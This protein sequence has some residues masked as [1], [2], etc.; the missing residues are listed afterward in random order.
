MIRILALV[1]GN[2]P[3]TELVIN[4]PLRFLLEQEKIIFEVRYIK[5]VI[6]NIVYTNFKAYDVVM[7]LRVCSEYSSTTLLS[8]IK[9]A[10]CKT[11][12][13]L[14]DY[15]PLLP[16]NFDISILYNNFNCKIG[17]EN[18]CKNCDSVITFSA[19]TFNLLKQFNTK[20]YLL[21]ANVDVDY[22]DKEYN[23]IN[24]IKTSPQEIKIGYAAID[25]HYSNFKIAIP[26]IKKLLVEFPNI[27]FECFFNLKPKEFKN[28]KNFICIPYVSGINNFYKILLS[29]NWDIGIA[30]LIET[31]FNEHKTDNKFREYAACRIPG[32]YSDIAT[33]NNSVINNITGIL[34]KNDID[35]ASWYRTIKSLII[36][37]DKRKL[38][39]DTAYK[40]I[41]ENY[42][43]P[44]VA[45]KYEEIIN[46]VLI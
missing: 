40:Y 29:R 12:Y 5:E 16:Q 9:N 25:H 33:F 11:I 24:K 22:I 26:A 36:D 6:H 41:V 7:F 21:K 15:F 35:N 28:Y 13:L 10:G 30:P 27:I 42:N 18:F 1:E 2:T 19:S 4:Q 8:K 31:A 44:I 38:I 37:E 23:K 34:C 39:K 32:I 20:T 3:S 45:K 17:I 14:D 46:S 43:I